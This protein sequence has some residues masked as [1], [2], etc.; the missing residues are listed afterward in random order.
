MTEAEWDAVIKVHLKG[1]FGPAHYAAAHWRERSKAGEEVDA[2]IINTTSPSGIYGNVGQ[3]NYG[4]AK[5]G[6]AAVHDHRGQG[7]GPLRR[8]RQRHRP[9]RPHPHDRGP[10]HGPGSTR[11]RKE[12][13][14][15]PL[16]R[17]DRDAGWPARESAGVTGRVFEVSGRDAVGVARA[18]TGARRPRPD[19][20]PGRA[21]APS[22]KRPGGQGPAQRRHVR[23]RPRAR[24]TPMPINPDAVGSTSR[25][26]RRSWTSKDAILYALGVGGPATPRRAAVHH[27]EQPATSTSRCCRRW[28]SS[29]APAGGGLEPSSGTFNWA[30]LV[31]GEQGV[32]PA[33]RVPSRASSRPASEITGIYD[34]GKG[35]VVVIETKADAGAS[36]GEPLFTTTCRSFIRGEG[37]FGGDRGPSGPQNAPPERAARPRGHLR[38][39]ADQALIYRLSGDRNPLHSDPSSPRLAGFDRPILHGLCTYGFTGRAL[40]HTLCDGDPPSSRRWTAGSPPRCSPARRSPSTCGGRRGEAVFQTIGHDGRVVL[41]ARHRHLHRVSRDAARPPGG[42]GPVRTG[43]GSSG[44]MPR[45][46]VV[47][48]LDPGDA[49]A[50]RPAPWPGA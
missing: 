45:S 24:R 13:H 50:R 6:I 23:L 27:R 21:S 38:H 36:D 37:G 2:R 3:T 29:S 7:A 5:A 39:P 8:H 12:Q 14:V 1:T 31:H 4:A 34:K 43:A 22:V 32:T 46:C 42:S 35:A 41:D 44:S 49:A 33:P 48:D 17:P 30:M 19:R 25:P 15:A 40:L 18:G 10:R 20:R 11:R 28:P 26:G 9:R 47:V 16:D